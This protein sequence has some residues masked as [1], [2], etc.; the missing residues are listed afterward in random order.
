L[1]RG[2]PCQT[3]IDTLT[4]VIEQAAAILL[5]LMRSRR[6]PLADPEAGER[7]VEERPLAV[8]LRQAEFSDFEDVAALKDRFGLGKDTQENWCRLWR[9]NPAMAVAKSR[10]SMGWVLETERG[11]V[12]YQGS[13]PL[14]Y[15]FGDRALIVA[16][17]TS[18]VVEPAYRARSIGLLASFYRQTGVDLALITTAIPSVGEVSK[19]L[20]A[21]ALPQQDYDTVLFWILDPHEF[22]TAVAMRLGFKGRT[23]AAA[24]FLGSLILRTEMRMRR[25]PLGPKPP[26]RVTEIPVKDIGEEFQAFWTRKIGEQPRL[27]AERSPL[28]LRW[29]FTI[30]GTAAT[31]A[32]LCC[33]RCERLMG[34]A[35]LRHRI[36]RRTGM[37]K[38]LLADMLAEQDDSTVIASLLEAAYAN[39][40]AAGDHVLEVMGL[41]RN[42]RQ[43]LMARNPYQRK[44]PAPSFLYKVK[45]QGL[46]QTLADENAWYAS[47]FDGDTTLAP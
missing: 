22:A 23:G 27:M 11:I 35:I 20:G 14:L 19:A 7:A 25:S 36:D 12:G 40:L 43:I 18:L 3:G 10:L 26:L 46:A 37:R 9:Q 47:A 1:F 30:P 13:I 42:I 41:P 4:L 32:V 8:R 15:R 28:C 31:T 21:H 39:A 29:H 24:T 34:Y 38:C 2:L 44:Y 33:Y 17:G 45:D 16:T 6:D 5:R